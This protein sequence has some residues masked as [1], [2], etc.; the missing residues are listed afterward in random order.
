MPALST[1]IIRGNKDAENHNLLTIP[2]KSALIGNGWT[3]PRTQFKEYSTYGCAHDSVYKPIFDEETCEKMTNTYSRCKNLM[4][5]CYKMPNSFTCVPANLYC[6]KTQAGAFSKTGLNPYDI[7]RECEGDSG[8]CYDLIE[9]IDGYAN[10]D[11]VRES[12][13]V[14]AQAGK[15]SGCN[16]A[17]GYRFFQTGDK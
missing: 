6:E 7:R 9:A 10:S 4:D 11:E 5:A 14:D 2:Y 13:G 8:L 1:E 12:L 16:D 3:D 15:Y 17:V